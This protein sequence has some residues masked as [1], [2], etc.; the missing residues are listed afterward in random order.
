V[1]VGSASPA[2]PLRGLATGSLTAALA[3]TA[4]AAAGGGTPSGATAAQLVLLAV[5]IGALSATISCA[6]RFRVQLVLMAAGQVLGHLLL[7]TV[8]HHHAN[9]GP[10]AATMIAAHLV[11]VACGAALIVAAG[12]LCAAISRVVRTVVAPTP[13]PV[14]SARPAALLQADQP[15]RSALQLAASMSHRGPPV[16]A[17]R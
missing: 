17:V 14:T 15:L 8:G 2:I 5:V 6:D 12:H 4:H 1:R 11:A 13:T 16:G 7:G 9:A 3:T 10:S